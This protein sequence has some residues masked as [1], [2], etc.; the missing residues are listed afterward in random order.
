MIAG[1]TRDIDLE[2]LCALKRLTRTPSLYGYVSKK[3]IIINDSRRWLSNAIIPCNTT[4]IFMP[5]CR[6]NKIFW[7]ANKNTDQDDMPQFNHFSM[8]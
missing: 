5:V 6:K 2:S 7:I 4:L 8:T 3:I 1:K